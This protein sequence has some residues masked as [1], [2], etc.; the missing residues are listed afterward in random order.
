M[1]IANKDSKKK[2]ISW[3]DSGKERPKY[4]VIL[5]I[6]ALDKPDFVLQKGLKLFIYG[7][8]LNLGHETFLL[9]NTYFM[10]FSSRSM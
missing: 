4:E 10:S 6:D 3:A 9:Q 5:L 7:T 8:W 1:F 2:D